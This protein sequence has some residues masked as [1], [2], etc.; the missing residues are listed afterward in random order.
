MKHRWIAALLALLLIGMSQAAAEKRI[1]PE[2]KKVY[3]TADL[4]GLSSG[5]NIPPINTA[6]QPFIGPT[7]ICHLA[8]T[9]MERSA[10]L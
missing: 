4:I 5:L 8:T 6:S 7:C 2:D 1:A 3:T 10:I 9:K